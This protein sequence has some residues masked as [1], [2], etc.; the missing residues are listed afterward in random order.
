MASF[1]SR[2]QNPSVPG[3]IKPDVTAPGVDILAAF[4]TPLGGD[5]SPP[6]YNVISGTCMSSPHTAGAGALI[7][8]LHPTWSPDQVRSALMTT[9]LTDGILKEDAATAADPFDRGAGRLQLGNAARAGLLFN[10]SADAYEAANPASGGDP[11]ALNIPSLGSDECDATCSW[12]RTVT[13]STAGSVTWTAAVSAPAGM[14]LSVSPSTFTVA[15]GESQALSVAADTTGLGGDGWRFAE[16]R[17]VPSDAS[18]PTVHLPVAVLASGE[19]GGGVPT[20]TLHFQGN[21]DEGCTGDGRADIVECDGP[22]LST[23]AE[24]D[25]AGAASWVATT[26]VDGTADRNIHDPNWVW[27]LDSPTT[28]GGPM[29]VRWWGECGICAPPVGSA[30]WTIRLWADGVKVAEQRITATPSSPTG[31]SLLETTVVVPETTAEATFVLHIDPVF[32]DVQNPSTIYYDSVEGCT[33][34]VEGP[35]DSTLLMPVLGQEPVTH[36]DLQVTDMTASNTRAPSGEKVTLTATVTN[37]GDGDAAASQTEFTLSDGTSLGTAET[38][39][40]A[41]GASTTVSIGWDTRGR[42]G[43]HVITATA[44]VAEAVAESVEDNN[45]GE[46]TVTVRGN[47]VRNGSFEQPNSAGT[48]P[49][50]WSGNS[51][52]AG[53]TSWS[54]GGCDGERSATITGT[55]G[56]AVLGGVA[57]FQPTPPVR[58]MFLALQASTHSKNFS[59]SRS[60][61]CP[62]RTMAVSRPLSLLLK[63]IQRKPPWLKASYFSANCRTVNSLRTGSFWP[64]SDMTDSLVR[65]ALHRVRVQGAR[66]PH[67]HTK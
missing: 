53:T 60:I 2:G 25:A 5:G 47:K 17:L 61:R 9:S 64:F 54:E 40:L 48:G 45:L 13:G 39:A 67:V 66:L 29:T 55:G 4:N 52:S 62:M 15:S 46:L 18:V 14:A 10:E 19:G 11:S 26:E 49:D 24:L 7:R 30:D 27:N 6:E 41:A 3:V 44:D 16:V 37:A 34:T 20:T 43:D 21:A 38:G 31:P 51:T 22:F 8:A 12:T 63:I 35:C 42:N 50:G 23:N 59:S 33:S 57:S 56:S 32:V 28:V 65:T 36:P 1:S 58:C